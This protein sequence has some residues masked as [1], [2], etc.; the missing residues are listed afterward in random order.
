MVQTSAPRNGNGTS[1][2]RPVKHDLSRCLFVTRA[3]GAEALSLKVLIC[4]ATN[5]ANWAVG[6]W[7]YCLISHEPAKLGLDAHWVQLNL[8]AHRLDLGVA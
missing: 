2:N 4:A 3:Y 6:N 5:S 7:Y 8:I 1:F